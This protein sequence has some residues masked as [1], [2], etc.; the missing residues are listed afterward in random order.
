MNLQ[1]ASQITCRVAVA[2]ARAIEKLAG[3]SA[4]I[5]WVNDIYINGRK[6]CG[7][8]SEA[9]SDLESGGVEYI[10]VGIGINVSTRDFPEDIKDIAASIPYGVNRNELLAEV[11]NQMDVCLETDCMAEYKSRSCVLGKTIEILYPDG[12]E[13]ATA[14]DIDSEGRLLVRDSFGNL[15]LLCSGEISVRISK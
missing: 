13:P 9:A 15:K 4:Q 3:S 1:D 8:L 12:K 7:I 2:V 6:V 11:L 14:L 5:K 10:V